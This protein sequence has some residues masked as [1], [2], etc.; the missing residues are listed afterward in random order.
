MPEAKHRIAPNHRVAMTREPQ[1]TILHELAIPTL[2]RKFK[3]P[4]HQ[5]HRVIPIEHQLRNPNR[6]QFQAPPID[7][8][9]SR[10]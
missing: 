4:I 2:T 8:S 9:R 6:V 1:T 10:H 5:L 3:N 7:P